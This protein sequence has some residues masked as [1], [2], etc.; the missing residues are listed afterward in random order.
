MCGLAAVAVAGCG[1][2]A[3]KKSGG[4]G[5][6]KSGDRLAAVKD[7]PVGGGVLVDMP[8]NAQLLLVQPVKGEVRAFNPTCPHQGTTVNPPTAG[9][10]T[11]PTHRSEFDPTTG[12]V[13]SG[14]S[15]KGLAEVPVVVKGDDVLLT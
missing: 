7:V 14:P 11:C 9:A 12:A 15:P 8:G 3:P 1:T 13:R 5:T 6:A 10:I 4:V 2:V